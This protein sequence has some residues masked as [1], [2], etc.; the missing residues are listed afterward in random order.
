MCSYRI[1]QHRLLHIPK[2]RLPLTLE[3][4]PDRATQMLLNQMIRVQE[5]S[6]Q[7]A[8]KLPANSGL[9]GTGKADEDDHST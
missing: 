3:V 9:T 1:G 2:R 7:L 4:F 6:R 5:R 8:S